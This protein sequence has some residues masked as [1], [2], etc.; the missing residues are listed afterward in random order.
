MTRHEARRYVLQALYQIEVGKADTFAA[1]THVLED[2]TVSDTDLAFIRSM[3]EGTESKLTEINDLLIENVQ[4]WTIDRIAKVDLVIL[5]LATFEL[6]YGHDVAIATILDEAVE[7]AK[8]FSTDASGKF[9]NG[10]L[11]RLLPRAREVRGKIDKD[12]E[13][14]FQG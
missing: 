5:R 3:V 6:L 9:V 12:L 14:E 13:N 11:A 7:L 10:A 2:V 8:E 4:N 1:I